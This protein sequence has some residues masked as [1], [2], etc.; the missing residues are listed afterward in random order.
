MN[1]L[2]EDAPSLTIKSSGGDYLKMQIVKI[3]DADFVEMELDVV[4]GGFRGTFINDDFL[5][6]Y[7]VVLHRDFQKLYRH[8]SGEAKFE[9]LGQLIQWQIKGNGRGKFDFSCCLNYQ[10]EPRGCIEFNFEFDQTYIP[11]FLRELDEIIVY[12]KRKTKNQTPEFR[13]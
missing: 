9:T 13:F 12:V 10:I 1:N 6:G 3:H 5:S 4:S 11:Y 8:L 2:S 7:F